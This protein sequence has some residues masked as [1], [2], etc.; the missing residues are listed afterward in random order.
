MATQSL[1]KW[2]QSYKYSLKTK[3]FKFKILQG[4]EWLLNDWKGN[5]ISEMKKFL[6]HRQTIWFT[7]PSMKLDTGQ[8]NPDAPHAHRKKDE[9][10]HN[11]RG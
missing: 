1:R 3:K 2:L 10:H 8:D 4:P 6:D 9:F 7:F 11:P 5:K